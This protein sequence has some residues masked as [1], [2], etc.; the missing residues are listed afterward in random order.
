MRTGLSI[1][2]LAGETLLLWDRHLVPVLYDRILE[3]YAAAGVDADDAADA[4]CRA[5]STTPG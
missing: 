3:L 4:G 2:D 1:R 5:R